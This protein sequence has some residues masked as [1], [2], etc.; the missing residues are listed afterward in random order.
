MDAVVKPRSIHEIDQ[1][2]NRQL[3]RQQRGS[4]DVDAIVAEQHTARTDKESVQEIHID[5]VESVGKLEAVATVHADDQERFKQLGVVHSAT[6]PIASHVVESKYLGLAHLIY[7]QQLGG[8]F[9]I[10]LC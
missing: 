3:Q 8:E 6:N 1:F 2:Q 10:G 4:V 7:S 5:P 9:P